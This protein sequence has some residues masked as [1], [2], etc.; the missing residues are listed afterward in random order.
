M[1][2][3]INET[4]ERNIFIKAKDLVAYILFIS[5]KSPAK[6]RYSLLN[7]LINDSLGIV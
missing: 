7:P 4:G 6:D 3:R 1:K 2:Q 5:G